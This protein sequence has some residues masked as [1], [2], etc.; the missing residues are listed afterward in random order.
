MI[1][2]TNRPSAKIPANLFHNPIAECNAT[3]FEIKNLEK[4][5]RRLGRHTRGSVPG[6]RGFRSCAV[7]L[8]GNRIAISKWPGQ[9]LNRQQQAD[10]E[11]STVIEA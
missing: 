3:D 7:R 10:A 8:V 9:R 11:I 2:S 4:A 5:P 6:N 1:R